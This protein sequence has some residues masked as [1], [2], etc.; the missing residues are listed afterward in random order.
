MEKKFIE[1]KG[2]LRPVMTDGE[3]KEGTYTPQN[4]LLLN[5][6]ERPG[7]YRMFVNYIDR[8]RDEVRK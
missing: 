6:E 7:I 2:K 8:K 5:M 3:G 1:I 4:A